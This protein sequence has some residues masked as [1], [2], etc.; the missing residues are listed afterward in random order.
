MDPSNAFVCI[1]GM[2]I[3]FIG[4]IIIVIL[5]KIMSYLCQISDNAKVINTDPKNDLSPTISTKEAAIPN[6]Q[7]LIAAISAVIAEDL[8]EDISAIRILS[9]KRV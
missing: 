7:E 8:G 2:S 4:L 1:M 3:V 9:L 6:R 5:C